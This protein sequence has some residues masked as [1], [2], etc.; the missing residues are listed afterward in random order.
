MNRVALLEQS[1]GIVRC[2]TCDG[3]VRGG[4][5]ARCNFGRAPAEPEWS[6]SR[7]M[8]VSLLSDLARVESERDELQAELK[9]V[10][11]YAIDDMGQP[12]RV[13]LGPDAPSRSSESCAMSGTRRRTN[14]TPPL[15]A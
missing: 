8:I 14:A 12:V 15:P 13:M 11:D 10:V 9:R 6:E 4:N 3:V 7:R 2:A 5:C 1:I